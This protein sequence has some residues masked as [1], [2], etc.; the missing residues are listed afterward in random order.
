MTRV[1]RMSLALILAMLAGPGMAQTPATAQQSPAAPAKKAA[2]NATI[3]RLELGST[4]ITGNQE[5]PKVM[6]VVP[7]KHADLGDLGGRPLK[8]LVDEAL[9]PVD[10][11]V[12]ARENN[13]F[14]ALEAGSKAGAETSVTAGTVKP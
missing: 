6:Y 13:Y 8:S 12:F 11:E 3:D 4:T 1:T 5:L 9:A 2:G 14:R 10:R 7:W